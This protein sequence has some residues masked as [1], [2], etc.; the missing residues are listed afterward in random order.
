MPSAVIERVNCIGKDN[1]LI[2]MFTN[3]YRQEIGDTTQD[4]DPGVGE[5]E[6]SFVGNPVL[7]E[8]VTLILLSPVKH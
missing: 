5:N 6:D 8:I 1:P 7:E 3:R 2:L 4:L